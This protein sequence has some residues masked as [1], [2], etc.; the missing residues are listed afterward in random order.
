[1]QITPILC[2]IYKITN[3]L[4]GKSY[5]GQTRKALISRLRQHRCYG[6]KHGMPICRA[7]AKYG[8]ENF[9]VDVLESEISMGDLDERERFWIRTEGTLV[10]NGYNVSIGGQSGQK[11]SEAS[12]AKISAAKLGHTVSEE[13]R[14]KM[15]VARLGKKLPREQVSKMIRSRAW[16]RPSEE[17]KDKIS[18]AHLGK[19]ATPEQIAAM[20][21]RWRKFGHP[22]K[23]TKRTL[24][25]LLRMSEA[26]K[27]KTGY[28]HTDEWKAKM[29]IR[30]SGE[31]NPFYGKT[32]PPELAARITEKRNITNR[33]PE[34]RK[35]T[36]ES[37]KKY[38]ET[39]SQTH[40]GRMYMKERSAKMLAA[41]YKRKESQ[42]L[43]PLQ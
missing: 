15:R 1:M 16:Y 35:R 2:I 19:K 25:S 6:I 29:S 4:N 41:R 42:C 10:P 5:V 34:G 40:A 31:R 38:W 26:L 28:P 13:S 33:S 37:S 21:E 32:H 20:K 17:T 14:Q 27:G 22:A 39:M 23:G 8:W 9:R 12:K 36:S 24:E 7:I 43:L 30:F 3:L 11:F 18:K